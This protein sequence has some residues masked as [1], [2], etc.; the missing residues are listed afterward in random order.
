MAVALLGAAALTLTG[1]CGSGSDNGDKQGIASVDGKQAADKKSDLAG[2]KTAEE[3]ALALAKCMRANGV[4]MPDPGSDGMMVIGPDD[5]NAP[6]QEQFEKADAACK[7]EREAM[8]GA[9]GEPPADLQDKMLKMARCMRG[10]GIDTPDPTMSSDGRA[11]VEID[12]GKINDPKFKDAQ[13]SCRKEVGLPEPG[14]GP[15]VGQGR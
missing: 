5:K 8:Q 7:K 15:N 14:R 3:A 9:V 11:S 1:A 13:E 12:P 10:K 2:G 4:D 6:T